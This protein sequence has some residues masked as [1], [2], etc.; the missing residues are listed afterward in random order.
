MGEGIFVPA[1]RSRLKISHLHRCH[2]LDVA[3]GAHPLFVFIVVQGHSVPCH[4]AHGYALVPGSTAPISRHFSFDSRELES[5]R[6]RHA[7]QSLRWMDPEFMFELALDQLLRQVTPLMPLITGGLTT[8]QQIDHAQ[9]LRHY[10][11]GDIPLLDALLDQCGEHFLLHRQ[12]Q[13]I[14]SFPA[15]RADGLDGLLVGSNAGFSS[16]S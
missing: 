1:S 15:L 12:L 7:D 3:G 16:K 14:R 5:Y 11:N 13:D 4:W 6:Q 2:R 10:I 9:L 8:P